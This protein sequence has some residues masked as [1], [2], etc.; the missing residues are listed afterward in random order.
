MRLRNPL[1]CLASAAIVL[2]LPAAAHARTSAKP[3]AKHGHRAM[4]ACTRTRSGR[5]ASTRHAH[6]T[7][8][9]GRGVGCGSRADL[10]PTAQRDDLLRL[11]GRLRCRLRD[12]PRRSL[13]DR[14]PGQPRAARARRR[15]AVPGRRDVRRRRADAGLGRRRLGTSAAPIEFGSYG[16]GQAR[17]VQGVWFSEGHDL[18]FQNLTLGSESGIAGA[19]FQGDGDGITI[20]HTTIEHSALGINA[21]GEDWTIADSTINETGDSGMLLGYTA[22]APG[23]PA[24][25]NDFLVTGNTISNTVWT[26][27]TR[28]APTASTT[29]SPTRRSRT[30]R[31]RTSTTTGS[32]PAIAT[33]RSPTTPSPTEPSAWPGFST[34][35]PRARARGPTTRS[36]T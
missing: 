5:R 25:G 7:R 11:A 27:R 14:D 21:E 23:D 26:Q 17:I 31:S 34:T 29:R 28:T 9:K 19:G 36:P 4:H 8:G 30:T 32:P 1:G 22:S 16:Q 35:R 24:G 18:A 15:G 2:C 33:T 12:Q 3:M 10:D 20:L 13:A 6:S